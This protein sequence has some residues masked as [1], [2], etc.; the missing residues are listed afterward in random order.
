MSLFSNNPP[1]NELI[2]LIFEPE[3]LI[4][5]K[6]LTQKIHSQIRYWYVSHNLSWKSVPHSKLSC[7]FRRLGIQCMSH[8]EH[9]SILFDCWKQ[10]PNTILLNFLF[11]VV[12]VWNDLEITGFWMKSTFY[13]LY[14]MLNICVNSIH[15]WHNFLK[16]LIFVNNI[17]GLA[18]SRCVCVWRLGYSLRACQLYWLWKTVCW[19]NSYKS[20]PAFGVKY[21]Y[22]PFCSRQ[23]WWCY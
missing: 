16:L 23:T 20:P 11:C 2:S 21:C 15:Y 5:Y 14:K 10:V 9:L 19:N 6:D 13:Y 18:H 17:R 22:T 4:H 1:L 12:Y 3:Q 7:G 8:M